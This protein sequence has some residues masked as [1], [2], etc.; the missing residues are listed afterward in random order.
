[1]LSTKGI[2]LKAGEQANK[3]PIVNKF[4]SNRCLVG[5]VYHNKTT[6]VRSTLG[7]FCIPK[8]TGNVKEVSIT[9]TVLQ[10]EHWH[11][12]HSTSKCE[13]S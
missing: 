4:G 10:E 3:I 8:L 2:Y 12:D 11:K 9:I 13:K 1:M 6:A 5:E 7:L